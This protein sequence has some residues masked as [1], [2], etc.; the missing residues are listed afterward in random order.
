MKALRAQA[1]SVSLVLAAVTATPS[2]A[3]NCAS[4]AICSF[5]LN[6]TDLLGSPLGA[7]NVL[8]TLNNTSAA[9]G[10]TVSFVS[11][12]L[13]NAPLAIDELGFTSSSAAV[14]LP[15]GWTQEFNMQVDGFGLF[16]S[17]LVNNAS[18]A[19]SLSFSLAHLVTSFPDNFAGAEF[20]ARVRF[21]NV[22][23]EAGVCAVY[24]SDGRSSAPKPLCAA[25]TVPEPASLLLFGLSALGV[26]MA[27]RRRRT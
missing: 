17:H 10:V 14:G 18:S 15:A 11:S 25:A 20:V 9:S 4:G 22:P 16:Q 24:A 2:E 7:L 19:L 12:N 13:P 6:N 1:V 23:G 5:L 8:V 21:A 26:A 3:G 27:I